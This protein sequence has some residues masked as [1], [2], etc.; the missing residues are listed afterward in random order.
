MTYLLDTNAVIAILNENTPFITRL[1]QHRP[2]E[3]VLSSIVLFE[4]Y[5][6]AQNSQKVVQNTAK[7]ERLPFEILDF[8][9]ED[10][11]A[12]GAIRANLRKKGT[13]IGEYDTLI[14]GQTLCRDLTLVTHNVSEF[15]RVD[16]L[17]FEDWLK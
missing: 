6:G 11:K 17:C 4:L 1:K 13:P 8:T 5:F 7:I 14:A 9:P 12:A 16:G 15:E 2:D 3:F 10:A